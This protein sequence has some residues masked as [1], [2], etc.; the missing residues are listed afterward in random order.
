MSPTPSADDGLRNDIIPV[1]PNDNREMIYEATY[2]AMRDV[3]RPHVIERFLPS[4][5]CPE[6]ACGA[7]F[8]HAQGYFKL[9]GS[10]ESPTV[11]P[12]HGVNIA[13]CPEHGYWLYIRSRNGTER[14]KSWCC[15]VRGCDHAQKASDILGSW[16]P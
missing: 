1:C 15:A 14:E 16:A 12:I 6:S 8:R 7:R 4:Y 2:L 9:S 13:K 5:A 3:F 11:V 10:P